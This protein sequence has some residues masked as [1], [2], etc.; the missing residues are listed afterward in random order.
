[1]TAESK[2]GGPDEAPIGET[3]YQDT[4][5]EEPIIVTEEGVEVEQNGDIIL[6]ADLQPVKLKNKKKET[7]DVYRVM[8]V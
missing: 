3:F 6:G 4:S 1:M 5:L 2:N 8:S 7:L